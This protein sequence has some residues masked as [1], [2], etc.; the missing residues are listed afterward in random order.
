MNKE[1]M[2]L[3]INKKKISN[4]LKIYLIRHGNATNNIG[5]RS[6]DSKLTEL[7]ISQ[8]KERNNFFKNIKFDKI[9][10]SPLSRCI[11]TSNYALNNRECFLDDRLMEKT[12]SICD[13]RMDKNILS[14][15]VKSLDNKYN[16]DDVS[17]NYEYV[18]GEGNEHFN[19]RIKDFFYSLIKKSENR[20]IL[21][22]SHNGWLSGFFSLITGSP[23]SFNNCEI[24][25][26][27][28][29]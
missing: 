21:I 1:K 5:I 29:I 13:K 4:I 25:I 3:L 26:I 19:N 11:Q 2:L 28:I 16:L 9:Y 22:C 20:T 15:Y 27:S 23:N 17:E 7:G 18:E 6:N 14:E 12:I 8:A 10:C 24:K